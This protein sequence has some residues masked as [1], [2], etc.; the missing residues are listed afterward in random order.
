[1]LSKAEKIVEQEV[2]G[3]TNYSWCTW[4]GPWK[5]GKDTEGIENQRKNQENTDHNIV[6]IS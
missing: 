1:M 3:N 5:I 6:K 4:N 2:D